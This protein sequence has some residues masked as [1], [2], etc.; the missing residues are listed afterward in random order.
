LT[1]KA[2][3]VSD[4]RKGRR[5][6][7]LKNQHLFCVRALKELCNADVEGSEL[8][9]EYIKFVPGKIKAKNLKIDVETAGSITLLLQSLLVPCFF[10]DKKIKL[11]IIG[12][13]DTKWSMPVDYF[14]EI[15][16]PQ[17]VRFC[18]KIDVKVDKRGYFP[19]G[20]GNVSIDIK[21]KYKLGEFDNFDEFLSGIGGNE[22]N[23]T[24]QYELIQVKGISHAS[25]DLEKANVADRQARAAKLVLNKLGCHVDVRTEYHDTMSVGSGVVLWAIFSKDRDEIDVFNPIRIGADSLGEKGKKSEVVG[26]EAALRLIEEIGFKAPVD[27]YLADNLIPW[28][29]L[30]GGKMKVSKVTNHTLSN[31]YVVEKFLGK[32]F[33]VDKENKIISVV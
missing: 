2:F 21:P 17:L 27:Q 4:I 16:V 12:G 14:K 30:F 18:E 19:K 6:S 28:L 15:L 29:G 33:D 7:G 32:V 31:I 13:T 3:E 23:L 22:I 5:D 10:A 25:S 20:Q 9:S 24:E 8:G 11:E 26:T 1:G